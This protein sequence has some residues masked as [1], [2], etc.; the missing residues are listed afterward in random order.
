MIDPIVRQSAFTTARV[1]R[2]LEHAP[3]EEILA[4][5]LQAYRGRTALACS[6]GGPTGIVA[7]DMVMH[8]DPSTPVYYLDTGLLFEETRTLINRIRERYVI[9]PIA[10]RPRLSPAE[11]AELYGDALWERNPDLC[12]KLRKVEPQERFLE[13]FDAWISGIRRD[14]TKDRSLV[15]VVTWDG[16][17]GLIKVSP[18]ARWT[19]EMVW[20]YVRARDLPYNELHDRQYPSIGCIP[21]TRSIRRGE[22]MRD[23]RWAGSVKVECGLHVSLNSGSA[24]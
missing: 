1:A 4:W 14:Q 8:I 19:E 18:F 20:R 22:G 7:I 3:P 21:C 23:G 9:E 12:C 24:R 2:E 6:F 10:V 17:F 5:A 13:G 11:Q 16:T 15:P